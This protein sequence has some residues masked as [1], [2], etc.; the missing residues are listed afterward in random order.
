MREFKMAR[1]RWVR[2]PAS[3][4]AAFAAVLVF[5]ASTLAHTIGPPRVRWSASK[6][7]QGIGEVQIAKGAHRKSQLNEVF[8][9][10]PSAFSIGPLAGRGSDWVHSD[11]PIG[12]PITNASYR[13]EADSPSLAHR[14]PFAQKGGVAHLDWS[15]AYDKRKH[16]AERAIRDP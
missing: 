6:I 11:N 4:V 15:Q 9:L 7:E 1:G 16:D 5:A 14:V 12:T 3:V 2:L 10:G 13:L 8:D